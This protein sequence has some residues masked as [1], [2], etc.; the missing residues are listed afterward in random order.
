MTLMPVRRVMVLRAAR[1]SRGWPLLLLIGVLAGCGGVPT[2]EPASIPTPGMLPSPPTASHGVTLMP[3]TPNT[4]LEFESPSDGWRVV[5]QG[6][7]QPAGN[8]PSAALGL[9]WPGDS[10]QRTT[11]G[12]SSWTQ[13]LT[14]QSGIWGVDFVSSS[15]GWAVGTTTLYATADGG[16]SWQLAGEPS[17]PLVAVDFL[18]AS[19]GYGI[20]RVGTLETSADGGQV[21]QPSS[22]SQPVSS[23]CFTSSDVGYLATQLGGFIEATANAGKSWTLSYGLPLNIMSSGAVDTDLACAGSTV[24]A[25]EDFGSAFGTATA[26]SYAV[27]RTLD[28]G[29]TW[30]M[31]G[32][33]I[34][35][36]SA[37]VP[38]QP[39]PVAMPTS[40]LTTGS[41]SAALLGY[42]NSGQTLAIA[43][44]SDGGR[45]FINVSLPVPS[46]T[47]SSA[48][49]IFQVAIQGFA[50]PATEDAWILVGTASPQ[51][52]TYNC[53]V[54]ESTDGG[55]SWSTV[56][57][58]A[59]AVGA[60]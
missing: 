24:W 7:A 59:V 42:G 11:D 47:T 51:P 10:V 17:S 55:A 18:D 54:I 16:Q 3:I 31:V 12:G 1:L 41:T 40:I 49:P 44:T 39:I 2:S 46:A 13:S 22:F 56:S 36:S 57:E 30:I 34:V 14:E 29:A 58:Q 4:A 38:G 19:N 35:G 37:E 5:G 15:T 6:A 27:A 21:W 52:G 23:V 28:G 45:H 8:T 60:Q 25:L 50:W 32:N 53:A 48:N 9:S 43:T 20:T 26:A 33:N